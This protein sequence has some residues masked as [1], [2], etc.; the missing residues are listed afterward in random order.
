MENLKFNAKNDQGVMT[1]YDTVALLTSEDGAKKYICYT[2][3][4]IEKGNERLFISAYKKNND[5]I[6]IFPIEDDEE[7]NWVIN[8][9][10]ENNKE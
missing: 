10:K 5:D 1:E 7:W 4:V 3:H 2:D 8:R 9:F 6:D